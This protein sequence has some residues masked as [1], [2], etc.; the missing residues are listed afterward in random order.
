MKPTN[1]FKMG[2]RI[3]NLTI[4]FLIVFYLILDL[5]VGYSQIYIN[6]FQA[7]NK[8]SVP[9]MHDFNDYSDWIELYNSGDV[10]IDLGGYTITDNVEDT[11]KWIIPDSSFIPPKGFMIFWADGYDVEP[12]DYLKRPWDFDKSFYTKFYHMPF[13]LSKS[14]EEIALYSPEGELLDH[15][16]FKTQYSDISFGRK[17]DGSDNWFYFGEPT[18]NKSN[19]TIGLLDIE[20]SEIPNFQPEGGFYDEGVIVKSTSLDNGINKY[21]R[22]GSYPN[23]KSDTFPPYI[24]IDSTSVVGIRAYESGKFPS[25]SNMQT[26]IVDTLEFDL[27]II[28]ITTDSRLMWN[29][30][31]GIYKNRIK[32]RKIPVRFEYFLSKEEKVLSTVATLKISGEYSFNYPQKSFTI[33]SSSKLG[34]DFLNYPFFHNVDNSK[35]KNIYMRNSGSPDNQMT[36]FR[37][38]FIH[39]LV[40]D[41]MDIDAQAYQPAVTYI[42]GKFWGIYNIREKYKSD[43][44][45]YRHNTNPNNI[46]LL[47]YDNNS[48]KEK[49][50]IVVNQGNELEYL[51]LLDFVR[52]NNLALNNNYEYISSKIDID[53]YINFMITQIFIDNRN[54]V[55]VNMKWWKE[56]KQNSKWRWLLLDTDRAFGEEGVVDHNLLSSLYGDEFP[57]WSTVL[58]LKLMK[59]TTFKNDFIQRFAAYLNTSF[60]VERTVSILDSLQNNIRGIM[61][62]HIE[63]WKQ[64]GQNYYPILNLGNWE[65]HVKKMRDFAIQRPELMKK[66]IKKQFGLNKMYNLNLK[67][68]GGRILVNTVDIPKEL[69]SEGKYFE[70]IPVHLEAVPLPGYKFVEWEGISTDNDLSISLNKD[71]SITAIF[72]PTDECIVLDSIREDMI[73]DNSCEYYMY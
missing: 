35:F 60:R 3:N 28:S 67:A 21:R 45:N 25:I 31:F 48:L 40:I 42:N 52:N 53:E 19:T 71:S 46:N 50:L 22:D 41:D 51:E 66:Y 68:S 26:Y 73:L 56:N 18:P 61:E 44:F 58:F 9:E 12:G 15:I 1:L 16:V 47:E 34:D 33:T 23:Q 29:D 49:G 54:W 70:N 24:V 10:S 32:Q 20:F 7:S 62:E 8:Y 72:I 13:K 36:F 63:R 11:K 65:N 5:N 37:D 57:E 2:L 59:N 43:Y 39:S 4:R 69:L 55:T 17:P 64:P 14:G 27:P 38:A 6:E 30:T